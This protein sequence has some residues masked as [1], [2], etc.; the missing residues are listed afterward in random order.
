MR[1]SRQKQ[2]TPAERPPR[3]AVRAGRSTA[4]AMLQ[5]FREKQAL[6]VP[7]MPGER[8]PALRHRLLLLALLLPVSAGGSAS[9]LELPHAWSR[10]FG[11]INNQLARAVAV[12]GSGCIVVAG[13]F[14]GTVDFG[15][16]PLVSAGG[17]DIFLARFD[18]AGGHIWS[19]R[20]GG[21]GQQH[22]SGLA[23]TGDGDIL[24]AGYF[25][26]TVDFG[27]LTHTSAGGYDAYA[28][29]F[30]SAGGRLW[31]RSFGDASDDVCSGVS[32]GARGAVCLVG[33]F[34]GQI[35]F[36]GGSLTSAGSADVWIAELDGP[37]GAHLRSR[38]FG[39]AAHQ[40]G[41]AIDA[42]S[43]ESV[44]IA[45]SAQ[46]TI[47]F[48][49]GPLA[50]AG[51]DDLFV[52]RFNSTGVHEWSRLAG[53]AGAQ[54]GVG[55]HVD[56]AG[57]SVLVL[58]QFE[59]AIDLGG[60]PLASAGETDICLAKYSA[61]GVHLWSRRWGGEGFDHPA[62]V[63][64]TPAGAFAVTGFFEGDAD[65]GGG[66]LIGAGDFDFFLA[67]YDET[68]AHVTSQ[69]AGDAYPQLGQAVAFGP[70]GDPVCAGHFFG[71]IDFDGEPLVSAGT[72]DVFLVR[73]GGYSSVPDPGLGGAGAEA[74]DGDPAPPEAPGGPALPRDARAAADPFD[75]RVCPS[76]AAPG[77][78]L[79]YTLPAPGRVRVSVF[80]AEGRRLRTLVDG[81]R[82]AGPHAV[83]W[84]ADGSMARGAR[85]ARLEHE[86][87]SA[88]IR[89]MPG[90]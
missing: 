84:A 37:S 79:R 88:S 4:G 90:D 41:R 46:G 76:P 83:P 38:R 69:S 61:G 32:I 39:D 75:L 66:P 28:A 47:D 87:A 42:A 65:F 59:G 63:A 49:G 34:F 10:S 35:D 67:T 1:E 5:G 77:A 21:S 36:G 30:D 81:A 20:F 64:G 22:A 45:G 26:G 82:E 43:G 13:E 24:L 80:D 6:S 3:R 11:D 15:G 62:A 89:V 17:Y 74:P 9:G 56:D 7:K 72:F 58:G 27:G 33:H 31:S 55:L 23:V 18:P 14:V 86:G 60:G 71:T 29:R 44:T 70:S 51:G 16:G 57:G 12:D 73:F 48:G 50:S 25:T 54:V 40:A 85:F 53:D 2:V 19:R 52:A 68:G 78:M 8:R